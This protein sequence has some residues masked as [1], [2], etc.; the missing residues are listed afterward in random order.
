LI[1]TGLLAALL[2]AASG[3]PA[4]A[5]VPLS[6][7]GGEA[8]I[9]LDDLRFAKDLGRLLVPAGRTGRLD[10][11]DPRTRS[12]ESVEGFSRTDSRTRGHGDGTTSADA[13]DGF[14][15]AIDRSDRTLVA[16]DP[17]ER[18]IMARAKLGGAPDYVRWVDGTR[19]VWVTEPDREVIEI[20][21]FVHAT[22]PALA[23]TG[24]IPVAA[25]PESLVVDSANGRAFT[26][27]FR[28][29][30]IAIDV[31]SHVV[32]ARWPNGCHGARGIALDEVHGW[33]LV[34]CKEGKA[35]ALDPTHGG[36][37]VGTAKTGDG[38]DGIAYS[39][40]VSHLYVPAGDAAT[41]SIIGVNERGEMQVLGTVAAAPG[42]HCAAADDQGNVFVC[43]PRR[44]RVLAFRDPF[45]AAR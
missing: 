5:P 13:G 23:S 18:R 45:L 42:A 4:Q 15:F 2:I 32:T 28:D 1:A 31:R 16:V 9:G 14:I 8:G 10:L 17:R 38:V 25:G 36:H 43:D 11:I 19:E 37:T 21:R 7:P 12:I 41:L 24:S 29:A 33:V 6:L 44:G 3:A 30:T 40:Q 39:P 22:T 27:T 35:V 34:G 26:N 20:F